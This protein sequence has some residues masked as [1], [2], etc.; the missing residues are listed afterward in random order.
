MSFSNGFGHSVKIS[1]VKNLKVSTSMYCR[2]G[3][4]VY[5]AYEHTLS[6]ISQANSKLFTIGPGGNGSVFNFYGKASSV[7][8]NSPGVS[9]S[10]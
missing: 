2:A 6:G 8:S 1:T 9:I 10:L 7:Y 5:G 4:T 3:V